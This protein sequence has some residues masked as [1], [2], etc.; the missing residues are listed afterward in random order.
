MPPRP[1]C[2]DCNRNRQSTI[3]RTP[4]NRHLYGWE[5]CL[6][7]QPTRRVCDDCYAR[8]DNRV[9][10]IVSRA[11]ALPGLTYVPPP[12]PVLNW[13]VSRVIHPIG[14]VLP[15]VHE[16]DDPMVPIYNQVQSVDPT[17]SEDPI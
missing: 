8:W 14:Y 11:L 15:I 1:R 4:T 7:F 16:V 12:V 17:E 10:V 3:G 2:V 5:G 13:Q 6:P 9:R